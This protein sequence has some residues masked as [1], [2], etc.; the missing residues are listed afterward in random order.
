MGKILFWLQWNRPK[1]ILNNRRAHF[2]L[3]RACHATNYFIISQF[4]SKLHSAADTHF[5]VRR[6]LFRNKVS[7]DLIV[8]TKLLCTPWC[9]QEKFNCKK[10]LYLQFILQNTF[11]CKHKNNWVRNPFFF[12]VMFCNFSNQSTTWDV[13]HLL[14]LV[15]DVVRGANIHTLKIILN[16]CHTDIH[17]QRISVLTVRAQSWLRACSDIIDTRCL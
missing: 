8:A 6:E 2:L 5:F 11:L 9:W 14:L 16:T 17:H 1:H 4:I 7:Q 3:C 10:S 13:N 12:R 15:T